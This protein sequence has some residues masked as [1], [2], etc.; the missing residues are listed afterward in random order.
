KCLQ[1]DPRRRYGSAAELADDLDAWLAGHAILARPV[2]R[3]SRALKWARRYPERAGLTAIAALLLLTALVAG[4]GQCWSGNAEYARQLA[5]SADH[6]FLLVKYAVGQA[7]RDGDLRDLLAAPSPDARR[8]QGHLEKTKQE[9][10]RWFTRPGEEPP[11]V[12]W[13]VM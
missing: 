2:G 10:L 13:F 4:F 6:Q 12:N 1:K 3:L 7:A 9:F 5:A 11:I 8:L